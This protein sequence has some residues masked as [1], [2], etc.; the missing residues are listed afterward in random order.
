MLDAHRLVTRA[1]KCRAYQFCDG[2]DNYNSAALMYESVSGTITYGN[3]YRRFAPPAGLPGQGISLPSGV[4]AYIQK[5]LASNQATL[6]VKVAYQAQSTPG[7]QTAILGVYDSGNNQVCL[8][9]TA[10]GALQVWRGFEGFGGNV[11]IATTGPSAIAA[12][13]WYGIE[14]LF[15]ISS[16]VGVAQVWVNGAQVINA[17]GLDTQFTSDSYS[18]QVRL[19]GDAAGAY[20]DDFRVWDSTGSTQNAP[21]GV[22]SQLITKLPS[23]AGAVTG[24]TANG[25]AANWQCVVDNPP[26]GDTTYVSAST[27]S[28]EDAYAMPSAGLS[29]TPIMVVARSYVRT[30]SGTHSLEIGVS[31]SGVTGF[32]ATFTPSSTYAF[33]SSCIPDDPNTSAPWTAAGADAAQHCKNELS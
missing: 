24:W 32:G 25:A 28:T 4:A 27:A 16:T 33:I 9:M 19:W 7:S 8:V 11:V 2:F 30:D 6:I 23:G 10:S 3:A 21:T 18:N 26:D 5:T 20:F 1:Q 17:T 15:T 29:Q 13:Q 31:S 12:G 22:D 14:C